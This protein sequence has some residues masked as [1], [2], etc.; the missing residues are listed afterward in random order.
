MSFIVTNT[1]NKFDNKRHKKIKSWTRYW[2]FTFGNRL[3][4]MIWPKSKISISNLIN[5]IWDKMKMTKR[6]ARVLATILTSNDDSKKLMDSID[7]N[8]SI[9][10]NAHKNFLNNNEKQDILDRLKTFIGKWK[11]LKEEQIKEMIR[12]YVQ[13]NEPKIQERFRRAIIKFGK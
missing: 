11:V 3:I 13:N 6:D 5:G 2:A 4:D 9:G 7:S 12:D 10:S 1:N 8:K